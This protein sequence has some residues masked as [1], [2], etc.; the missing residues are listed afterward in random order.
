MAQINITLNQEELLA[1]ICKGND[2]LMKVL[3]ERSLDEV[4]KAQSDT[5]VKW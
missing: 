1:L 2:E 3:F 4:M 5:G